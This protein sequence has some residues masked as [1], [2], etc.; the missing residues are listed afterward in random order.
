MNNIKLSEK[1]KVITEQLLEI[2][3]LKSVTSK[4]VKALS[5]IEDHMTCITGPLNGNLDKYTK[6]QSKIFWNFQKIIEAAPFYRTDEGEDKLIFIE[7]DGFKFMKTFILSEDSSAANVFLEMYKYEFMGFH[8]RYLYSAEQIQGFFLP[9]N[10]LI[11]LVGDYK[12]N[13]E[14]KNIWEV[15]KSNPWCIK[16]IYDTRFTNQEEPQ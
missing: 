3:Q 11:Y 13:P 2:R 16:C 9:N 8:P 7:E 12:K 14:Y 6:E 1:D 4:L 15:I 5:E 10:V